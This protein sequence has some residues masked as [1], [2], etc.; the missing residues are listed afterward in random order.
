[1][2]ASNRPASAR[3]PCQARS[4]ATLDR[5]L[6][7]TAALLAEKPFDQ[8]PV[9]EI[10]RRA[11]TSV[12]AFYGRFA[13]KESLLDCFDER[14]F[15]L[16]RA[17][18]DEFFDSGGWCGASLDDS[19]AQLVSLVVRNHRRHRGVLRALALRARER[20]ESRFRERAALH[21]RYVLDRIK[22][23]LLS[24]PEPIP[25]RDPAR[26]VELAFRF[27]VGSIR[28]AILFDDVGGLVVPSDDELVTELTRAFLAYLRAGE[29]RA[30]RRSP[31]ASPGSARA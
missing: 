30:S 18:C 7:A 13:D 12:G 4:R 28:E 22:A 15:K 19:V 14:F 20:P 1:M 26:A 21:N 16:A 23:H 31:R 3:P 6:D 2:P 17:S 8:A 5:L 29:V 27:I 11:G 10:A 25:H 24:R 9:A